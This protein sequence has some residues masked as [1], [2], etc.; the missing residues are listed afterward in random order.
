MQAGWLGGWPAGRLESVQLPL[1]LLLMTT[2][3][4]TLI[5]LLG[6]CAA[7]FYLH[8]L[9]YMELAGIGTSRRQMG[10]AKP[11]VNLNEGK[12][13]PMLGH[14]GS[15]SNNAMQEQQC[16]G[17]KHNKRPVHQKRHR[18]EN[19]TLSSARSIGSWHS[20]AISVIKINIVTEPLLNGWWKTR[21]Q[22]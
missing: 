15:S 22:L 19:W 7:S 20:N 11:N 18:S 13:H 10:K 14:G 4:M 8:K 12:M 5:T 2:M 21:L 16:T 17:R 1:L 9:W 3:M 6:Y